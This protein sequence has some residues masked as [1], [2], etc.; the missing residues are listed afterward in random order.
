MAAANRR[1]GRVVGLAAT[2]AFL[3]LGAAPLTAAPPA[4]ADFDDVI[5]Q[6]LGPFLDAMTGDLNWDAV[7]SPT[8][9]DTF[10]GP[11]HWDGVFAALSGPAG[12]ASFD[13]QDPTAWIQQ[14]IY[15]PIHTGIDGWINSTGPTP[16]L[17]GL[18][19][20]SKAFGLGPMIAHGAAGTVENPDGGAA[21]WLFGDGGAGWDNTNPG[22]IGGAGGHAGMFGNGGAG[23]D[24]G[25][26]GLGGNGGDGGSGGWLM[27]IGGAGGD[28]G[29]GVYSGPGDL[30]ALGGAG[31]NPG[32]LGIHGTVGHYGTLDGAPAV[33]AGGLTTTGNWITDSDGRVVILHG[34][35]QVYK[36]APY[37]PSAGGF[38]ED[39][40]AFL[41]ANGFNAVRLG[42]I[43]AAV[44]P[45]P[46]VYDADYLAAVAA[47]VKILGDHGIVSILDMHQDFYNEAFGGEGAPDWAVQTGGWPNLEIDQAFNYLLNP[48]LNHVWDAFWGNSKAAD[49]IG[50]ENH[51]AQM[52][53]YTANYFAGDANVAG[54]TIMNEPWIG[55]Q[56]LSTALGSPHFD[57]QQLTPF[58]NQMT[59]AIRSVDPDT[60]V[61]FEPNFLSNAMIPINLGTVNDDNAVFAF[62]NY[63]LPLAMFNLDF[64]CTL[65][66]EMILDHAAAYARSQGIP[67][68]MTE[69][70]ATDNV[71]VIAQMMGPVNR[72]QFGWTEWAYTGKDIASFSP[73]GQALVFDPSQPPVGDNVDWAKLAVL[74]EPYPQAIAGTPESW[75][76]SNGTFQLSYSTEMADGSGH[77][78]AGTHTEISVPP[79]QYPNGYQVS[80]TGGHVVSAAGAP[81]LVIAA[82]GP[83]TVHVTVTPAGG[84]G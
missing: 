28:A 62:H 24:G 46:G 39:D 52:W 9:W 23:G 35:N 64:G 76:F 13:P 1:A 38:D 78:G 27:G 50:L 68:V 77:F 5:E 34:L 54:Y 83:G 32:M 29:D 16:V 47:T 72:Y 74:S 81:V 60:P 20:L 18:N 73:E 14:Y 33:A 30:P 80:V 75:S 43:W 22:G 69:F 48:A 56:W 3:V 37:E 11:A 10:F 61:Y 17:D 49:G 21:G 31:G 25:D 53:Q 12:S 65:N 44:E 6:A 58:Y 67:A 71:N 57:A 79:I 7:V 84:A 19:E 26:G 66:A 41:A 82:D 63:C 36:I 70:G 15:T 42:I 4:Q 40:A 59:M 8:A 2:G 45:E 55:S 51:Y